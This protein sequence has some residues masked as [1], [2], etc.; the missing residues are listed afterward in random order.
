MA[1]SK[2]ALQLSALGWGD[3]VEEHVFAKELGRRWRFDYA[4]PHR[5]KVALEY[6]GLHSRKSRHT[7]VKGY[8]GDCEK[9]NAAALLGW[10]VFRVTAGMVRRGDLIR[11]FEG[12]DDE[13]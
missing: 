10:R 6:E 2:V 12:L 5:G 13:R 4:W 9:Y 1:T 11:I 8:E 3:Y 7:T